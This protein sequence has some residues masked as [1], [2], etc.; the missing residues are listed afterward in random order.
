M[1][2]LVLPGDG[3][4]PEI[5]AAAMTALAALNDKLSLKLDFSQRALGL[6][7][8]AKEGSTLP[9][10]LM[11]AIKAADGVVMGP[12][13]TYA[14]PPKE[15]GGINPSATLRKELDL[16]ANIRPSRARPGV[17]ALTPD[18]DLV[19]AR[20]NTEGFYADRNMFSGSG[21]FM[22]TEDVA[23]AVRKITRQGSAR[24][25]R[26]AFDLAQ[27]RRKKVT[28]VT[29]ANVLKVSEGLFLGEVRK[30]AADYPD[31]AL[32]EILIDAMA[33][34]LVRTPGAFDVVVTT[35]MYGD[36]LSDEAAELSGGLGLGGSVNAGDDHGIAQAAHGS[37][38]D[39]AGQGIA[40]PTALMVSAAMLLEWLGGKHGRDDLIESAAVFNAAIDKVLADP[41]NHTPDLGGKANTADVGNAVAAE[42]GG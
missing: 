4:G 30:V 28:V 1:K 3:I 21:E 20:E 32:D 23:L 8:L 22:P 13:D 5:T 17:P 10:S 24:I 2:I 7:A 39:I 16:Y 26:V 35:N 25:A 15:E 27:R 11:D 6:E 41:A 38:P 29:K 33:A 37:A 36:I 12:V 42:I 40:N 9:D 18:M 34:M 19:I 14:Y 31:V